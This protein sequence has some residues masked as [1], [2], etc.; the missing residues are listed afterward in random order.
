MSRVKNR[1]STTPIVFLLKDQENVKSCIESLVSNKQIIIN[2]TLLSNEKRYRVIDFLSGYVFA[3]NGNREKLED[4]I[5]LF[6]IN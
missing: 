1:N 5:Y 2:L 4:L 6:S 3:L